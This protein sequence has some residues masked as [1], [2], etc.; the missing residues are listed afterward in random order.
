M[1]IE[2][3]SL[4]D[5]INVASDRC[6]APTN[7]AAVLTLG[8]R[9]GDSRVSDTDLIAA[10]GER[11]ASIPRLRQVLL[12]A[13]A[14]GGPPYWADAPHF[15]PARH[16]GIVHTGEGET[17]L[18]D[19]A[20]ELATT[21]LLPSRP[22]WSARL[23]VQPD[24]ARAFV[25]V[26]HHLVTDGLGGL[27]TLAALDDS[28]WGARRGGP[29]PPRPLPTYRALVS[30]AWRARAVALSRAPDAL[31]SAI[32]GLREMGLDRKPARLLDRSSLNRPTGPARRVA[33]IAIDLDAFHRGMRERGATVND[34]VV[35]AVVGALV[36]LLAARGEHPAHLVVS[37]PVAGRADGQQMGNAVGVLPVDVPATDDGQKRLAAVVRSTAPRRSGVRGSSGDLMAV[38][39]RALAVTGL[40]RWFIEHQRLVTTSSSNLRG[41]AEPLRL[42]GHEVTRLIPFGITP[43]NIGVGFLACSYAGALAV[44]VVAD[45]TIVPEYRELADLVQAELQQI[46]G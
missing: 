25:V 44:T 29:L 23:V 7:V 2:R 31:R 8:H 12:P 19:A 42:I 14:A 18:L 6:A 3:L 26:L 9:E 43:G 1:T 28:A 21:R 34:G 38:V 41:P 39:A 11:L 46:S 40:V 35:A 17:A 24:G 10:F 22:P 16:L 5:A 15:D 45:P 36:T 37:V 32:A 30:D 4:Q 33:T 20:A 27:A 13:P